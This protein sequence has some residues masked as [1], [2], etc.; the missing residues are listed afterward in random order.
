M[1]ELDG[2]A[3]YSCDA[4]DAGLVLKSFG[5][6]ALVPDEEWQAHRA[7]LVQDGLAELSAAV[8]RFTEW[9]DVDARINLVAAKIEHID[10][11][12]PEIQSESLRE[13]VDHM[14]V[15]TAVARTTGQP[16]QPDDVARLEE[17]VRVAVQDYRRTKGIE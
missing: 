14:I 10:R 15:M 2:K 5:R 4:C 9:Q 12:G 8:D 7:R 11:Y 13:A 6:A 3:A 16:F 17:L 1:Y